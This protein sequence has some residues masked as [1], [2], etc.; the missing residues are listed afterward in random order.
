LKCRRPS[1]FFV[2]IRRRDLFMPSSFRFDDPR[3]R[4]LDGTACRADGPPHDDQVDAFTQAL[5]YLRGSGLDFEGLRSAGVVAPAPPAAGRFASLLRAFRLRGPWLGFMLRSKASPPGSSA[6]MVVRRHPMNLATTS[7][8]S[9]SCT[10]AKGS[11]SIGACL[12][13][14]KGRS[15]SH[16]KFARRK[17][18]NEVMHVAEIGKM[19]RRRGDA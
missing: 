16:E 11:T 6:L 14:A 18:R 13:S 7:F 15:V 4:S 8:R 5:S 9:C 10:S 2:F 3:K 12:T 19:L 1:P 17:I